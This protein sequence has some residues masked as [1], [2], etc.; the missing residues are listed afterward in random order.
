VI[1]DEGLDRGAEEFTYVI[2]M[3]RPFQPCPAA[4]RESRSHASTVSS[5]WAMSAIEQPA[6][7][8][9]QDHGD[10]SGVS[11]SADSAMKC[12]PQKDVAPTS[13]PVCRAAGDQAE[14]RSA[15]A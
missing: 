1:A 6:E 15:T 14:P 5:Y 12:T 9:G 4:P 3:M 13:P 2:G 11:M 8:S 7:R 10:A